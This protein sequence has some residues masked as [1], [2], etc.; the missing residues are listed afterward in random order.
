[1]K[2]SGYFVAEYCITKKML[3]EI[4]KTRVLIL[5]CGIEGQSIL[6]FLREKFPEKEITV[7]DR[8]E[9]LRQSQDDNLEK[10]KYVFGKDYLKNLEKYDLI[11]KS[12]GIKP[13]L[14]ELLEFKKQG[15]KITSAT[16]IF[17]SQVRGTVLG[18]TGSKG[19]STVS[20]LLY[21]VLKSA[22]KK[23]ELIGN[24]GN[25]AL[26]V[27]END[28]E[29]SL[30]VYEMSSYQLEDLEVKPQFAL[31]NNL[32]PE[33]LD[34]H[35]NLED[36]YRAKLNIV[37][38][39]T[40]H[41]LRATSKKIPLEKGAVSCKDT[42]GLRLQGIPINSTK[43]NQA[44]KGQ[45]PLEKYLGSSQERLN[46]HDANEKKVQIVFYNAGSEDLAAVMQNSQS[47]LIPFND[48]ENSKL[49][50]G[51]LIYKEEEII[52]SQEINLLGKH[53]L[54]NALG[55]I[56]LCKELGIENEVIRQAL[57]EF[58]GLEHRLEYVGS[59]RGIGFYNDSISTTPESTIQAIETLEDNLDTLIVGGLDRGYDFSELVESILQS[60][61]RNLILFPETGKKIRDLITNY[62]LGIMKGKNLQA[63]SAPSNFPLVSWKADN[64]R[65]LQDDIKNLPKFYEVNNMQECLKTS[66]QVTNRNKICLLSPAAPSY[67][68]FKNFAERGSLYKKFIQ[69]YS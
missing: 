45:R 69:K 24:I 64:L 59:F 29:D 43:S 10:V 21:A 48:G 6:R 27:L 8:S 63:S 54:E 50:D 68:L 41:E 65:Q 38:E 3:K 19:K 60:K 49:K 18:I 46:Q 20:S 25:P 36:Y 67:N 58:K 33:H 34:Y 35:G 51:K 9:A 62:E 7:A 16:N 12:P 55:V 66:F 40:S 1:M 37:D 44:D 56:A 26:D 31:I 22:G 57:S 28:S 14:S 11:I 42:G 52:Q 39:S 17:M 47:T 32:F 30:Y 2:K 4:E 23:V 53:N 5:G 15:G 13:N 61:I